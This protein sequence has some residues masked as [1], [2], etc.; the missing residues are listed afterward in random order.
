MK[1]T[2]ALNIQVRGGIGVKSKTLTILTASFILLISSFTFSSCK[3]CGK[4]EPKSTDRDNKTSQDPVVPN[5]SES[6]K[7]LTL[8][9]IKPLVKVA[10]R[11]TARAHCAMTKAMY[12][13]K[14]EAKKTEAQNASS[15]KK[16][17]EV[18]TK[19]PIVAEAKNLKDKKNIVVAYANA[20][21]LLFERAKLDAELALAANNWYGCIIKEQTKEARDAWRVTYTNAQAKDPDALKIAEKMFAKALMKAVVEEGDVVI[22][23]SA[24]DVK[25]RFKYWEM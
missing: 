14:H 3:N 9:D 23:S 6:K 12:A 15:E 1:Q 11:H 22:V 4:K 25:N 2:K 16:K 19:N 17:V 5:T 7:E 21:G 10:A 24:D 13:Y 18:L 20:I 8:L